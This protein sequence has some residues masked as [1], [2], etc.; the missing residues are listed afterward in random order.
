MKRYKVLVT[1]DCTESVLI[2]VLAKDEE[3]AKELAVAEAEVSSALDWS[4]DE[5][6]DP[7]CFVTDVEEGEDEA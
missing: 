5:V 2:E 6:V 3:E 4:L 1:R 7:T